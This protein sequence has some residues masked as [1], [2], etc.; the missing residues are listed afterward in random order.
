MVLALKKASPRENRGTS[1]LHTSAGTAHSDLVQVLF[2]F[3]LFKSFKSVNR[4]RIL[5]TSSIYFTVE[6]EQRE[7]EL[8]LKNTRRS[9]QHGVTRGN[10]IA[11]QE[12]MARATRGRRGCRRCRGRHRHRCWSRREA[13]GVR[14]AK[15]GQ[16]TEQ[17]RAARWRPDGDDDGVATAGPALPG[18]LGRHRC[19]G[20]CVL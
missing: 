14:R 20:C 8:G 7:G 15:A 9:T 12:A 19:A 1:D 10:D 11:Q 13:S 3:L 5:I 16:R 6:T 17:S 18:L 4:I 2:L